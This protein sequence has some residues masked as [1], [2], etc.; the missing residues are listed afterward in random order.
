M[1][2]QKRFLDLWHYHPEL[3]FVYI[4]KGKG[5]TLIGDY[6]GEFNEGD[7]FLLGSNLPHVF[8][9]DAEL[10]Y[11]SEAL[12]LY[13]NPDFLKKLSRVENEFGFLDEIISNSK[14]GLKFKQ[15][16]S[17]LIKKQLLD[18]V[19]KSPNACT[20]HTLAIL[21][22]L[23]T[24]SGYSKLGGINCIKNYDIKDE[25]IK[26]INDYTMSNFDQEID[27]NTVAS[28]IGMNKS[29]FCRFFKQKTGKTYIT[30]LNEIRINRACKILKLEKTKNVIS[31]ACF[32]SGYNNLSYFN[33]IFK[34]NKGQ[35]PSEYLYN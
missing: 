25:R 15:F 32:K 11:D 35:T 20:L 13:L 3:E 4:K 2:K 7:L 30:Y 22:E 14:Y 5:V 21:N 8:R 24:N 28:L 19:D 16:P 27:L 17:K 1:H 10:D 26:Q 33:R 6:I 9:S 34:K 29:A 31:M 23:D 12:I 18:L